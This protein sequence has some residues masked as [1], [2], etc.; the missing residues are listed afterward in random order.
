MLSLSPTGLHYLNL[1]TTFSART[2]HGIG[3]RI[4]LMLSLRSRDIWYLQGPKNGIPYLAAARLQRWALILAAYSYAI[5]Y[6]PTDHHGYADGLSR[7]PVNATDE[8]FIS[9]VPSLFNLQQLENVV[10]RCT[11]CQA[12][13]HSPSVAPLQPWIWPARPWK[14]IHIDFAGPFQGAMFLVAIDAHSK[15]PEM[16][17][18]KGTTTAITIELL[19][20]I[21]SLFGLPQQQLVSNNGP[22]QLVSDDFTKYMRLNGVKHVRCA[23]YHPATNGW[24]N[25][26]S[27]L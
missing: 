8:D 13:K 17:V 5:E 26:L 15:W 20:W 4:T 14:R 23:P 22:T 19:R 11:A 21:F 25:V 16:H 7:L 2:R 10:K 18:M 1:S 6:C 24:R 9:N 3:Q 12:V 27:R